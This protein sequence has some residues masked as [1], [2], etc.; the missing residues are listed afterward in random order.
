MYIFKYKTNLDSLPEVFE[1]A[2]SHAKV[3]KIFWMECRW[4]TLVWI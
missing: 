1:L 3:D 2:V 4:K